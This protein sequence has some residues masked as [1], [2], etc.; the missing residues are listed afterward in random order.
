M[1]DYIVQSDALK[2][3]LLLAE[4]IGKRCGVGYSRAHHK[5]GA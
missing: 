5:L 3:G 4:M 2:N 1:M